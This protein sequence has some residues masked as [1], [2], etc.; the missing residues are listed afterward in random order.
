MSDWE[1]LARL[2]AGV[3]LDVAMTVDGGSDDLYD[4]QA[5]VLWAAGWRKKPSLDPE[6]IVKFARERLRAGHVY[7]NDFQGGFR[8]AT[9]AILALL[10]GGLCETGE[11]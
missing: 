10:D 3:A 8:A 4:L 1:E 2:L 9:D 5:D 6:T 7:S 11:K